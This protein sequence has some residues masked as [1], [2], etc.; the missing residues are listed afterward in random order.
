MAETKASERTRR[1]RQVVSAIVAALAVLTLIASTVGTWAH[2]TLLDT[3][4]Y[5]ATVAPLARDPQVIEAI[6]SR[7]STEAMDLLDFE[8][9]LAEALPSGY[10][11]VAFPVSEAARTQVQRLLVRLMQTEQFAQI[12]EAAN[13]AAH[14]GVVAILRN[15]ARYIDSSGG[16]VTVDLVLLAADLIRE[17][18]ERV[19]FIGERFKIPQ[20]SSDASPAEVRQILSEAVGRPIPEDFGRFTVIE[21]DELASA[22]R[23][24]TAFDRAI[25]ALVVLTILLMGAAIIISVRRLRTV[26]YIGVGALL[27]L[28][29][30]R[31]II[32]DIKADFLESIVDPASRAAAGATVAAFAKSLSGYVDLLIGVSLL[33]IAT[34]FLAGEN[35][36]AVR[37]RSWVATGYGVVRE[38]G[39]GSVTSESPAMRWVAVNVRV[40][41]TAAV[42]VFVLIVLVIDVSF[43]IL[44]L[45][46]TAFGLV[47]L[48][49]ALVAD[50]AGK[51]NG[52][53]ADSEQEL[54]SEVP[55]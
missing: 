2:R 5:V 42:A 24:V 29:I 1:T 10:S 28:V 25:V 11:F 20:I 48:A 30:S 14:S 12:W 21:S 41:Q 6:A 3:D 46:I 37:F 7:L 13:R 17:L 50:G 51:P 18:G 4:T 52:V 45:L 34:A 23:A 27:A 15:D 54:E 38:R 53:G 47:E 32:R 36:L 16:K 40:I 22:Q 49:L 9:R 8:R 31:S 55:A 35:A 19:T 44:L 43:S 33:L 39:S 26:M